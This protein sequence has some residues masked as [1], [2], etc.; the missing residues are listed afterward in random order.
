MR[1]ASY[2]TVFHAYR[3][4]GRRVFWSVNSPPRGVRRKLENHRTGS[5]RRDAYHIICSSFVF[6]FG[7]GHFEL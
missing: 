1:T 6:H 2:L 5:I 3:V 7:N 4:K